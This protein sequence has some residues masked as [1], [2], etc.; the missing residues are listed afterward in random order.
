MPRPVSLALAAIL[1]A[2]AARGDDKVYHN[3][4]AYM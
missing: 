4:S 1:A 3:S 2:T